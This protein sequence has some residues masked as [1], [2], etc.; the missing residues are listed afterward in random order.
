M[1]DHSKHN[2]EERGRGEIR[3]NDAPQSEGVFQSRLIMRANGS[4]RVLL[5]TNLWC[6][7][8]CDR[9]SPQGIR[10]TAQ[11]SNGEFGIY[12]IKV[13]RQRG[14]DK[15]RERER[16][17]ERERGR[18]I[19]RERGREI[20]RERGRERGRERERDKERERERERER[21][22]EKHL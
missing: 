7:M 2:W 1:F 13:K 15:E 6:Q 14:R 18:E 3:L 19:R 22:R 17:G 4:Y 5:N 16:E 10:I 20:R 21:G 8:T 12:L 9:A 11:E